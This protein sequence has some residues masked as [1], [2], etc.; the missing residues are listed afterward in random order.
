MMLHDSQTIIPEVISYV[1][2]LL[3]ADQLERLFVEPYASLTSRSL[4]ISAR[5]D[6]RLALCDFAR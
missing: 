2:L 5:L 4:A 3:P 6:K 1:L